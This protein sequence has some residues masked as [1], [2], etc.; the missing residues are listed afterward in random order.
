MYA[1]HSPICEPIRQSICMGRTHWAQHSYVQGSISAV[2]YV[3][4][5]VF[6]M[7]MGGQG[8]ARHISMLVHT[9]NRAHRCVGGGARHISTLVHTWNCAHRCTGGG[10]RHISTLVH[11]WNRAHRCVVRGFAARACSGQTRPY[12]TARIVKR[13]KLGAQQHTSVGA[14]VQCATWHA[15]VCVCVC[16]RVCARA[17]VCVFVCVCHARV[18]VTRESVCVQGEHVLHSLL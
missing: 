4:G 11:T 17:C 16:V 10:A 15:R 12:F 7:L 8:V 18:C 13:R 6:A 14:C 3:R 1:A 9:W 2:S 5:S